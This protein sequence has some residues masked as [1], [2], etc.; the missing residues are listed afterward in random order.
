MK[1]GTFVEIKIVNKKISKQARL[2]SNNRVRVAISETIYGHKNGNFDIKSHFFD[3]K[4]YF[5]P[6]KRLCW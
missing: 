6:L 2:N 5:S 3:R 4:C 1:F